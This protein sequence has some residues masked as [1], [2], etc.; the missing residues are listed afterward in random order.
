LVKIYHQEKLDKD[1]EYL[2]QK[3]EAMTVL[4]D[5][6]NNVGLCW[7]RMRVYDDDNWIGYAM[8]RGN[9]VPMSKLA[10]AVLYKKHFP[11]LNRSNVVEYLINFIDAVS[12]L[13]NKNVYIGDF[14]LNNVLCDPKSSSISLI[15]CDSYQL[16]MN[17]K[18]FP[19][20]VGSPDLTP[21]EHHG[22]DFRKVVRTAESDAFSLAIILFKCL[23][24]GRHPYDIV[25]GE[26]PVSNMRNGIFPYGKGTRGLPPGAWYNIWSH[27][28]YR[29]KELFIK[30]F[31]EG[32]KKP[33]LRP[34]LSKWKEALEVYQRDMK[35][36]FHEQV[37]I[38][39]EPKKSEHRG[40]SSNVSSD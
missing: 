23:M 33:L 11:N 34:S 35:K 5:D 39:S 1:G 9:G 22:L 7:P 21:L 36:G 17:G 32:A 19:C 4:K 38:P 18:L 25:G 30:N 27:M 2:K 29:L 40:N 15:D 10:H 24:L 37:I 8:K 28:P 31:T 3:I 20:L 13:H 26:D 16:S 14:N 12:F 6:F